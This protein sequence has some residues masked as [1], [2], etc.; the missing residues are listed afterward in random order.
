MG[1]LLVVTWLGIIALS[2]ITIHQCKNEGV[3]H[4]YDLAL[5]KSVD[6]SDPAFSKSICHM[7]RVN[8]YGYVKVGDKFLIKGPQDKS[9]ERLYGS[10]N[11]AKIEIMQHALYCNIKE[12]TDI[13]TIPD[14]LC[15]KNIAKAHRTHYTYSD[16]ETIMEMSSEDHLKDTIKAFAVGGKSLV[17]GAYD[18]LLEGLEYVVAKSPVGGEDIKNSFQVGL[19]LIKDGYASLLGD[20]LSTKPPPIRVHNRG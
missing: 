1:K 18:N 17:V 3:R 9:C 14:D 16:E 6:M 11:A 4:F 12:E 8:Q 20:D 19:K 15:I 13:S 10:Y 7:I 5:D 2:S